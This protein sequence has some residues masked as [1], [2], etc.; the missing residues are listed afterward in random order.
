MSIPLALSASVL[1]NNDNKSNKNKRE[2]MSNYTNNTNNTKLSNMK[3]AIQS[4]HNNSSL[5][6]NSTYA[7]FN[8][9]KQPNIPVQ[10]TPVVSSSDN[11]VSEFQFNSLDNNIP[12]NQ[13]Y[14]LEN[15]NI[16]KNKIEQQIILE[17]LDKIIHLF[18]E[19]QDVKTNQKMEELILY[20]FLG[21]FIIYVLDSFARIGK[22]VR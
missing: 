12:L 22:Y 21:V 9:P 19:N 20:S 3:N 4:I 13:A 18:E 17:K 11:Y 10:K 6:E 8:L 5:D 1:E 14:T 7:D 15:T 2:G 16:P